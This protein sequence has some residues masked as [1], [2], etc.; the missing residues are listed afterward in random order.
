[1]GMKER[2]LKYA[3][4]TA[5]AIGLISLLHSGDRSPTPPEP[6]SIA[7]T[8]N[9]EAAYLEWKAGARRAGADRTLVLP[10]GYVKGL[11]T[12]FVLAEGSVTLDL[13]EGSLAVEVSGLAGDGP[14]EVWLVDNRPGPGR[15]VRA[16]PGDALLRVGAL[17]PAGRSARLHAPLGRELLATFEL[18]QVVVTPAGQNPATAGL[19]FGSPTLFQRLF[20]A[21]LRER[22]TGPTPAGAPRSI[23]APFRALVPAPVFAQE[24]VG[25]TPDLVS[26]V[27]RGERLFFAETFNGNGRTCGTCHPAE[28]N[29][30][31]DPKFIATLPKAHPLFVAEFNPALKDLE[32]PTLMRRFGLI[33]ENVDGL[34]DPTRKF[35]MRGVPHTIGLS[36]SL[37][38]ATNLPAD[39]GFPP[40]FPT[41]MTGWSGDG[42]PRD[43]SLRNFAVGA[44]AQHFTK[45]LHRIEG[46]DFRLPS[47][48]ELNAIEAFQLAIGRQRDLDLAT[49]VLTD[50][51]AS[52]GKA[53]F[54]NG[55]GDPEA[56]G[57]CQACHLNAGA[58]DATNLEN[59]NFN[60]QVEDRDAPHRQLDPTLPRDGGFGVQQPNPPS[61]QTTCAAPPP[62]PECGF[63]DGRFNSVSLVEA[64]D[65]G[66]FFHNN[67]VHTIEEAIEHYNSDEFNNARGPAARFDL[68]P[69]QVRQ[70]GKFLR[71][72]NAVDNDASAIRY[73]TL[74]TRADTLRRAQRSLSLAVRELADAIRVLSE[75]Q[76]HPAAVESLSSARR[77]LQQAQITSDPSRRNFLIRAAIDAAHRARALMVQGA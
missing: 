37:R 25:V 15:S 31:I 48:E 72:I 23:A 70:M 66:P 26:L 6:P 58:L 63:G 30:T 64:A 32:K 68:N 45:T 39:S 29:F 38:R 46:V 3:V 2:V 44:V 28:N 22:W 65:S 7:D 16:E 27:G 5:L 41:Q 69:D 49:L 51:E 73:A 47:D 67:L 53:L 13:V 34:E 57:R 4:V 77:L 14:H 36:Q 10:L 59:R 62:S 18:D 54:V 75:K 19:L 56:G 33:L 76:L 55:T 9:L 40:G 21:E 42:A 50:P 60:T 61:G 20:H 11:S 74:A 17:Q 24:I 8:Q 52:A 1:M 43:G 35:V 12:R 71:V